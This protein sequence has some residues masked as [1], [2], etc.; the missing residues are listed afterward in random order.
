MKK[1]LLVLMLGVMVCTS[2]SGWADTA[3]QKMINA[4]KKSSTT[5]KTT[6][7]EG[8]QAHIRGEAAKQRREGK[9]P[10]IFDKVTPA[11]T[12]ESPFAQAIIASREAERNARL[13]KQQE[14]QN[15]LNQINNNLPKQL[16][17]NGSDCYDVYDN[18]EN[19]NEATH[20][21]P[22]GLSNEIDMQQ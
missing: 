16:N 11:D 12:P 9:A 7:T 5:N 4:Q 3:K 18:P 14:I 1:L 6:T 20:M 10:G 13:K 21:A 15:E 2:Y 8:S 17:C 19:P 22:T